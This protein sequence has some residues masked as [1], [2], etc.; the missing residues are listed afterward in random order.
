MPE[1]AV[2]AVIVAM[3]AQGSV[4]SLSLMNLIK[5]QAVPAPVEFLDELKQYLGQIPQPRAPH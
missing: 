5:A 1:A 2:P 3:A 4:T